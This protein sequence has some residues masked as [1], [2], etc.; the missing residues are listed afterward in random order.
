MERMRELFL[1]L[2]AGIYL[3]AFAS[4]FLQVMR[5]N[6]STVQCEELRWHPPVL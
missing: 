3:V 1:Q 4:L 5:A 2:L 6:K